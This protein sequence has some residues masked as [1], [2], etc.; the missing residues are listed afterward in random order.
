SKE[1]IERMMADAESHADE[2]RARKEEAEI[3]NAG[4]SLLY[5]TEKFI[6]ENEEKLS[7]GDAAEKK[8]ETEA[9]LEELKTALGGS[10]YEMIKSATEKVATVSQALG[11]AIYA[12]GAAE[13][14][15]NSADDGVEDAEV[16]DEQEEQKA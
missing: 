7:S 3:R 1:E 14:E 15:A 8:T 4:D 5:S 9:A 6:K 12:A 16:I 13:G 2:D 11:T 10:N